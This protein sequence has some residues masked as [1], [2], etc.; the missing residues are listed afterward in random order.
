MYPSDQLSV[1][2]LSHIHGALCAS[3]EAV[4]ALRDVSQLE[5][6]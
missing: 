2:V 4:G 1:T 5:S 6:P 3:S